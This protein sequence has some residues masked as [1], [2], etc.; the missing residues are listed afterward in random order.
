LRHLISIG[1]YK[2]LADKQKQQSSSS[3]NTLYADISRRVMQALSF[4][5]RRWRYTQLMKLSSLL[6]G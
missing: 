1:Q 6:M 2:A 5:A 4:F 3:N